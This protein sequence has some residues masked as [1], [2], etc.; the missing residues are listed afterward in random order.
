MKRIKLTLVALLSIG[1]AVGCGST[2]NP[3]NKTADNMLER[4]TYLNTGFVTTQSNTIACVEGSLGDGAIGDSFTFHTSFNHINSVETIM[5]LTS[6]AYRKSGCTGEPEETIVQEY[7]LTIG[8]EFNQGTRLEIDILLAK[9]DFNF[10]AERNFSEAVVFGKDIV[11]GV[12]FHTIL[13]GEGG[14]QTDTL[15][16]GFGNPSE[17]SNGDTVEGRS[18]DITKYITANTFLLQE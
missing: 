13:V 2:N 5:T 7:Q 9:F 10:E 15:K 8:E 11:V 14:T 12:P 6:T 18:E 4:F 17:A 16:Y 1:F 3:S